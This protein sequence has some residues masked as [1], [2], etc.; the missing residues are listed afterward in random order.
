MFR[1]ESALS[2]AAYFL[3]KAPS[4]E[5]ND[6]QLMK[7][8]YFA[9]RTCLHETRSSITGST[10]Y[11]MKNGPVLSEVLDLKG[12]SVNSALWK[13][14]I[15]FFPYDEVA[16]LSNRYR[17]IKP[18]PYA[19]HLSNF[20]LEILG[21][22]W[23]ENKSKTKWDMVGLAHAFPEW[24][25]AVGEPNSNQKRSRLRLVDIFELGFKMPHDQAVEIAREIEYY[26]S[27]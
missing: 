25:K 2:A 13:E 15:Q 4:L 19:D 8:L 20:E 16:G 24:N 7:L 22:V 26:E 9:E 10:F 21:K 27:I 18:F 5:L 6:L 23:N 14:H 3:E 11:S 1:I 12:D 17:L